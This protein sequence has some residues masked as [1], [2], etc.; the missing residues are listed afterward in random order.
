M[1]KDVGILGCFAKP[2][3]VPKQNILGNVWCGNCTDVLV[4]KSI[5]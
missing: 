2:K 5:Q 1:N 3:G 4:E